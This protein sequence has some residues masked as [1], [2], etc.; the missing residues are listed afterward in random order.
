MDWQKRHFAFHFIG[1]GMMQYCV[2]NAVCWGVTWVMLWVA[3]WGYQL[4]LVES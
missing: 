3:S 4:L 1:N 2:I